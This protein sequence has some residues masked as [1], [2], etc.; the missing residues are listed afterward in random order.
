MRSVL[1][2][3]GNAFSQPETHEALFYRLAM[4]SGGVLLFLGFAGICAYAPWYISTG[5][6]TVAVIAG[7]CIVFPRVGL[8][9]LIVSFPITAFAC[10]LILDQ[11]W[12]ITLFMGKYM[13]KIPAYAPLV[14]L[15]FLGVCLLE[16][17]RLR[18]IILD[19]PL[20]LILSLLMFYAFLSIG[21][22]D[23]IIHSCFQFVMMIMNFMLFVI[24]YG[25]VRS[26]KEHR[27]LMAVL[28]GSIFLQFTIAMGLYL[29]DTNVQ[30]FPFTPGL[31]FNFNY[32]GGLLLPT[33]APNVA[34]GLQD[35]HE[36]S[37]MANM[38]AAV[39]FGLAVAE[40]KSNIRRLVYI[41]LFAAFVF[42][43]LRTESRAG[44]GSLLVVLVCLVA[45]VPGVRRW[46]FRLWPVLVVGALCIYI[47][48][49]LTI[50]LISNDMPQPRMFYIVQTILE[51]GSIIDTGHKKKESGR[52]YIYQRSFHAYAD[53]PLEGLGI[54]NL[55]YLVKIPHAH[56]VY[57][58]L[59]M[60]YGLAGYAFIL[61]LTTYLLRQFILIFRLHSSYMKTMSMAITAGFLGICVHCLVDFDYNMTSL[62]VF[63]AILVTTYSM[64]LRLEKEKEPLGCYAS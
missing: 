53:R 56:S 44:I 38:A 28:L 59:F 54:G 19:E 39:A 64:T 45:L 33:G 40:R 3:N 58:A 2:Q 63:L 42:F 35:F 51:G 26:E 12:N 6:L 5:T 47:A 61:A 57:F 32:Y 29:I 37:L 24:I 62:W 16:C 55:K 7:T 23:N 10:N 1:T 22:T 8:Y 41:V 17:T 25:L 14:P 20:L 52:M 21:W 48:T 43:T 31:I 49:H 18:K 30:A 50:Q 4:F 34:A 46:R 13:D 9:V 36:T 11:P 27:R 60:D 15:T